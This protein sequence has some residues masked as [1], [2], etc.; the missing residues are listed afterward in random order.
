MLWICI[1]SSSKTPETIVSDASQLTPAVH[2]FVW[3]ILPM[4]VVG[5]FTAI[6]LDMDNYIEVLDFEDLE[7]ILVLSRRKGIIRGDT[8][9]EIYELDQADIDRQFAQGTNSFDSKDDKQQVNKRT[10]NRAFYIFDP[11]A[12]DMS[13]KSLY[14]NI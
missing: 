10:S 9:N 3:D 5:I 1:L 4:A 2:I 8:E 11:N 13:N 7:K 12:N 14:Q 6:V